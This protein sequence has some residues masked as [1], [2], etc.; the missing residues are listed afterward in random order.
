MLRTTNARRMGPSPRVRGKLRALLLCRVQQRSIP[1]RAGETSC[2]CAW[3]IR[4]QVHPRACGGN[5]YATGISVSQ[6][7]PSPRVRGKPVG[8]LFWRCCSGPSP[9][10]RGNFMTNGVWVGSTG[11]SPRVRGKQFQIV[12]RSVQHGSI[13]RVREKPWWHTHRLRG[14]GSIPA[15]A[16]ETNVAGSSVPTLR[17][18]PRACGGNGRRVAPSMAS[19]GPSPRVRGKRHL[20]PL[21]DLWPRSIPA[22]AGETRTPKPKHSATRVHPRACG[23]NVDIPLT[24]MRIM[25]PSPRVRGNAS[26]SVIAIFCG[27]PSPRVRGKRQPVR[28]GRDQDGS[29]PAR[30]G[31]TWNARAR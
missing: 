5:T 20:Q 19:R 31:E 16:G 14:R 7:G 28:L 12:G 21:G 8:V 29:I 9:R 15:R 11:P 24:N 1:A 30:A 23:G 17:V 22:R 27:G 6:Q 3:S 10:V 25:G 2:R 18:H 26:P 13:P 4:P